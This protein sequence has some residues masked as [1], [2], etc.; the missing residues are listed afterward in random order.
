MHKTF[1]KFTE[2]QCNVRTFPPT[3]K[4]TLLAIVVTVH[5]HLQAQAPAKPHAASMD[6]L[7]LDIY[8]NTNLISTVYKN[9][10]SSCFIPSPAPL[11]Y[12][13]IT[14]I[15]I[16]RRLTNTDLKLLLDAAVI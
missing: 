8:I 11:C 10:A 13:H 2:A 3:S 14:Y 4:S 16:H 1:S 12:G 7:M 9:V 5:S 15:F 6:L